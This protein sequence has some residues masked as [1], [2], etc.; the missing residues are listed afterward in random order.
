MI[1]SNLVPITHCN[2]HQISNFILS[3]RHIHSHQ[4]LRKLTCQKI[5]VV[6]LDML[7]TTQSHNLTGVQLQE[8]NSYSTVSL[9]IHF[10]ALKQSAL[11]RG[12][13]IPLSQDGSVGIYLGGF[14]WGF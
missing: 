4:S 10:T 3:S 13:E 8:K 12:Q 7:P 9:I 2:H 1:A 6:V 14:L 11:V 5:H